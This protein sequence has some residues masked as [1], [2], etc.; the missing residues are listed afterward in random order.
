MKIIKHHLRRAHCQKAEIAFVWL[1]TL[2]TFVKNST[3]NTFKC[4]LLSLVKSINYFNGKRINYAQWSPRWGLFYIRGLLHVLHV[5]GLN[6]LQNSN[7]LDWH[8]KI[9]T[10]IW[11]EISDISYVL[12]NSLK[13]FN[14]Y[15]VLLTKQMN[16]NTNKTNFKFLCKHMLL[17]SF[18]EG[19]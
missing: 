6:L 9:T 11:Q 16:C 4:F 2:N 19:Y 12:C 18:S 8:K 17:R 7:Q 15:L 10:N 3:F 14:L 5:L 13:C 1:S